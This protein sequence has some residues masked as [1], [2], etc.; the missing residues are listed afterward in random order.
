MIEKKFKSLV[1]SF[2]RGDI[3]SAET[4][5]MVEDLHRKRERRDL[6]IEEVE[7]YLER[8]PSGSADSSDERLR[9]LLLKDLA[10]VDVSDV[11]RATPRRPRP[12][13]AREIEERRRGRET[14]WEEA[15]GFE[16]GRGRALS[17]EHHHGEKHASVEEDRSYVLPVLGILII[18]GTFVFMVR[19][20]SL[21][22][23]E[24]KKS[25]PMSAAIS[26]GLSDSEAVRRAN[27]FLAERRAAVE[28]TEEESDGEV[29]EPAASVLA[30]PASLVDLI[31]SPKGEAG[32]A[33]PGR[34]GDMDDLLLIR[35]PGGE[36][37]TTSDPELP[38]IAP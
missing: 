35:M 30:P 25:D 26:E 12:I 14:A 33:S 31:G 21:E 10:Q 19:F 23:G 2:L 28:E 9:Q 34:V 4:V 8:V 5:W 32:G 36:Q 27:E 1:E 20:S 17:T 22:E 24:E 13:P 38:V 15:E 37:A 7:N 3:S 6:F 16:K 18:I 11:E 29:A